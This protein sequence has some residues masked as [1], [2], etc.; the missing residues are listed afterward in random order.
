MTLN[1]VQ[2]KSTT[3]NLKNLEGILAATHHRGEQIESQ[4]R[5]EPW[6]LKLQSLPLKLKNGQTSE[7][8]AMIQN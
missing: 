2:W 7:V 6:Y 4:Q 3:K 1:E 8:N 5:K